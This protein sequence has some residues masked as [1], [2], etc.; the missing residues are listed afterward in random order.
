MPHLGMIEECAVEELWQTLRSRK[1]A[2][3]LRVDCRR[4]VV[5]D[6]GATAAGSPGDD[7]VD[8]DEIAAV[9]FPASNQTA[10]LGG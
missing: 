8:R 9:P 1:A 5:R 3:V 7:Y 4:D 10:Q 2:D 6:E